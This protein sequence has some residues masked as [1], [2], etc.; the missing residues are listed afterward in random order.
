MKISIK[1]KVLKVRTFRHC[2]DLLYAKNMPDVANVRTTVDLLSSGFAARWSYYYNHCDHTVLFSD[3]T[4]VLDRFDYP[5]LWRCIFLFYFTISS[6]FRLRWLQSGT[7]PARR[8]ARDSFQ[9]IL[10]SSWSAPQYVIRSVST[11][12]TYYKRQ[13]DQDI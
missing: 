7:S 4:S 11:A 3:A 10:L 6:F 13:K 1:K 5:S 2:T 8:I 12:T 9:R